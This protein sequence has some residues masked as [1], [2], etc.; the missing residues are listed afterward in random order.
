MWSLGLMSG[1]GGQIPRSDVWGGGA[2]SLGLMSGEGD[3]LPC[4]LSHET[5]DFTY[6]PP[7]R[8]TDGQTSVKTIPSRNFVC[9]R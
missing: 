8:M 3:T 6:H 4:D 2:R 5:F 1:E 9:G 7:D